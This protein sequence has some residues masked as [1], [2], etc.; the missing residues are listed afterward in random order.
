MGCPIAQANWKPSPTWPIQRE[1]GLAADFEKMRQTTGQRLGFE[2]FKGSSFQQF[3]RQAEVDVLGLHFTDGGLAAIAVDSAFHENGVQ[4]GDLKETVGRILKKMIRT[5]F[6]LDGYFDLHRAEI[7]FATPKMHNAVHEALKGCWLELQSVLADC[8]T[9]SADSVQLRIVTNGDFA[10]QI[11][12]PVLDRMDQVADTSELFLRAQQLVRL[13][14]VAPRRAK[15]HR[16]P[17]PT[18]PEGESEPKIGVHVRQTMVRL[19]STGKLTPKVVADLCDRS[20]CKATFG[21]NHAFLQ[22]VMPNTSLHAQGIDDNGYSRYWREPLDIDGARFLVCSQ[23]FAWQRPAFDRW[24]RD[25]EASET[26]DSDRRPDSANS[27]MSAAGP[28]R[29]LFRLRR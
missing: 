13:C 2:I 15:A 22:K 7:V 6:V 10:E 26:Q 9:L 1:A 17:A 20:R 25:L 21:F 23:W 29:G 8:T 12:Q 19:A 28:I 5:A 27:A 16:N 4:Y 3:M 24:V 18:R 11:V 14:E